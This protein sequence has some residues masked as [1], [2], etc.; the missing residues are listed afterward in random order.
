M[1]TLS[2]SDTGF[3]SIALGY[4]KFKLTG[5]KDTNDIESQSYPDNA[6]TPISEIEPIKTFAVVATT[7]C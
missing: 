6:E 3:V 2:N 5:G 7:T 1:N 4:Q